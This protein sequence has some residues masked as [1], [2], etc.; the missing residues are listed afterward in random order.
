[1]RITA[2][3]SN[4]YEAIQGYEYQNPIIRKIMENVMMLL[5]SAYNI[6]NSILLSSLIIIWK[7][8]IYSIYMYVQSII[9]IDIV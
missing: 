1:M 9:V 6:C 2:L 7:I 4:I 5:G 8:F 3:K